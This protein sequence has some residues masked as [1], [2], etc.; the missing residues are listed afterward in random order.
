MYTDH[1]IGLTE[2]EAWLAK[3]L[4]EESSRLL[5]FEAG[6]KPL[7]VVSFTEIS[8]LPSIGDSTCSWGFYIGEPDSPRGAGTIM[9]ILAVDYAFKAL[10]LCALSASVL[11]S[12]VAS[13]SFHKK[14]GFSAGATLREQVLKSGVPEDVVVLSLLAR[15]WPEVRSA[16][17]RRY[18]G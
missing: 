14:L 5:I 7:G 3:T 6:C 1:V 18:E 13:L 8:P 16:V 12:N 4:A 17:M 9:G 11:R 2:H 15:E 10:D